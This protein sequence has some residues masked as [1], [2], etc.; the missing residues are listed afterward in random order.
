M[1]WVFDH[2]TPSPGQPNQGMIS[3]WLVLNHGSPLLTYNHSDFPEH[4][5]HVRSALKHKQGSFQSTEYQKANMQSH[6]FFL[7]STSDILP[8]PCTRS[9]QV[10]LKSYTCDKNG[11]GVGFK[12]VMLPSSARLWTDRAQSVCLLCSSFTK[13]KRTPSFYP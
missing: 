13:N 4:F 3:S 11:T 2:H 6:T 5:N 1:F 7:P 10:T 9:V 12:I 8:T